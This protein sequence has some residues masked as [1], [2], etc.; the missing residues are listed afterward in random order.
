MSILDEILA[1]KRD[2][3]RAIG[4]RGGALEREARDA[5]APR[6]FARALRAGPSPRIV[7]ELKRASPS[8]GWI[9][10]DADARALA[11]AYAEGGAVAL[12][13]LTDGPYFKGSLADLRVA[14]E[15]VELPVLRKDFVIDP[16]QILEARASGADAVLL[17]VAALDDTRLR[18]L[19]SA[20]KGEGLDALVE[21][22]TRAELDRAL[23]AGAE[24]LGVNNRD[25][26]TFRVDVEVSRALLPHAGGRTVV[27]ESGLAEGATLASLVRAG[28][29]AFLIGEA[30]MRAPDPGGALRKLREDA[31]RT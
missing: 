12:S 19:L 2:E 18:E 22:H 4:A 15:A 8:R 3:V 5:P 13:I 30:F 27:S 24:T 7:A 26:R 9:R 23:D 25:L 17:I 14:R 10:R 1:A 6:G 28:V 21:V 20:A 16:L 29:H 31:C 11:R